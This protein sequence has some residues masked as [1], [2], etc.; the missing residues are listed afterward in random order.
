MSL[1]S[2]A[3]HESVQQVAS[4][5]HRSAELGMRGQ[6]AMATLSSP[7]YMSSAPRMRGRS[8]EEEEE[9][10]DMLD[11]EL[12][13]EAHRRVADGTFT[14]QAA[15]QPLL[16]GGE[17]ALQM[18]GSEEGRALQQAQEHET[19]RQLEREP[20]NEAECAS[21][22]SL[23]EGFAKL[24]EDARKATLELWEQTEANFD[25]TPATKAQIANEI[26]RVDRQ[27]NM[28][29]REDPRKWFV[30]GMCQTT[31]HNAR[32]LN[33]VLSGITTKLELLSS[34]TECPVCFEAF[35]P[36]RPSTT[37]GCAHK[38]CSECWEH[39]CAVNRHDSAFCPLCRH[40]EFL[41]RVFAAAEEVTPHTAPAPP[42]AGPA[43]RGRSL[44]GGLF[45]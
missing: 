41:G 19:L 26:K 6:S 5:P 18:A 45:G 25:A 40:E 10:E 38:V 11:M 16:A 17:A 9:E 13:A 2:S 15:L 31:A 37:L 14:N 1:S 24:T 33:G 35:G 44:L 28:G 21:K 27:E 32:L 20:A 12:T 4:T 43:P 36:E 29:I 34:Q 22:F 3:F 8:I 39:W 42:D 23:Y 30:H 7:D